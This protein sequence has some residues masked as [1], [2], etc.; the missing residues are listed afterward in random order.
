[1]RAQQGFT[2]GGLLIFL[3]FMAGVATVAFKLVP[4]YMDYYAVQ[5]TLDAMARDGLGGDNTAIRQDFDKRA[6]INFLRDI[7]GRD[8][9]IQREGGKIEMVVEISRKSPLVGGVSLS[10]DLEARAVAADK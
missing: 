4:V 2:L 8:L 6:S 3:A 1:M 7:T 10:V 5:K 9:K